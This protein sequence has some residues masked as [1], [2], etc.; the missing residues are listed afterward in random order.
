MDIMQKT[1]VALAE[2]DSIL[3]DEIT[4]MRVTLQENVGAIARLTSQLG[5]VK[6]DN[7]SL[8]QELH[9]ALNDGFEEKMQR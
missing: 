5:E 4:K 3:A 6:S 8:R 9:V 2:N 7:A 1:L